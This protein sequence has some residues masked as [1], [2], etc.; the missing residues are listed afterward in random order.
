VFDL[1]SNW[2]DKIFATGNV[3]IYPSLKSEIS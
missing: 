3:E 1:S 2:A